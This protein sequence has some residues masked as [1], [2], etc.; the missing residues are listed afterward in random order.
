MSRK[1]KTLKLLV[2]GKPITVSADRVKPAYILNENDSGH[3]IPKPTDTTPTKAPTDIFRLYRV[4]DIQTFTFTCLINQEAA[5]FL[6]RSIGQS[7]G[8]SL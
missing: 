3:T 5:I 6:L 1:D 4:S 7:M 2:R 8:I